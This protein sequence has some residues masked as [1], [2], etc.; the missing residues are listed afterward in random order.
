[1]ASWLLTTALLTLST[2]AAAQEYSSQSNTFNSSFSLSPSQISSAN[3]DKTTVNNVNIAIHFEQSN[4]ATGSIH[5]D[6]FYTPPS[7][8]SCAPPGSLLKVEDYTNTTLYTLP[9]NV[10]LSRIIFQSAIYLNDHTNAPVPA[11]AYILWPWH[12]RI[13]PATGKYAVVGWAHGTSGIFGECAPSHIRNL[14]YQY[15]APFILAL[16]GYVVVAP[17]YTGLG[18]DR[19]PNGTKI[20]HPAF[21]NPAHAND[22]FYSVEAAQKAYPDELSERFVLFG[23]SQ[24]GGAAWGAAQRQAR[25]PVEGH[26][27]TIAASP[28][29][30]I[31]MQYR[32]T[33]DAGWPFE[34]VPGLLSTI[35]DFD[36]SDFLTPKGVRH[37]DLLAE[38]GG[39]AS[40]YLPLFYQPKLLKP[41]WDTTPAMQE[42]QN[43]TGNGGRPISGPMLVLQGTGDVVITTNLT[44]H[45]VKE[46]CALYPNSEI[47]YALFEGADHVPTLYASQRIWLD[48]IAERFEGKPV[49]KGCEHRMYRPARRVEAYQQE[50]AYYME[51][52][53]QSYEVA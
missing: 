39:C 34:L 33:P 38:I 53:T 41:G 23:H 43:L 7:N 27:G 10:A 51:I 26:L 45:F 21:N 36:D 32:I 3:L 6:P 2:Y 46:T 50:L 42:F 4:W 30:D 16:Q 8:A 49:K 22:L 25:Q 37:Y 9:P 13:D 52:A 24:G 15:S 5:D 19:W 40:S 29:T 47:E 44:T 28:V 14:W 17:D 20:Q 1:M 12:P 11:S 48:W 35:P 31:V 18:V